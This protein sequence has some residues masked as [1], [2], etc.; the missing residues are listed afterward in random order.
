MI[1]VVDP[2][3]VNDGKDIEINDSIGV[4]GRIILLKFLGDPG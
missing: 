2:G 1:C 3:K 4:D